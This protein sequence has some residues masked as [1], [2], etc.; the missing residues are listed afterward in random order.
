MLAPCVILTHPGTVG[1]PGFVAVCELYDTFRP[2]QKYN[3]IITGCHSSL[4]HLGQGGSPVPNVTSLCTA[5]A[6]GPCHP[7]SHLCTDR[8]GVGITSGQLASG[9]P[10]APKSNRHCPGEVGKPYE[11]TC[12]HGLVY[13]YLFCPCPVLGNSV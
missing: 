3:T 9:R 7:R 8:S 11:T 10:V 4:L 1:S 13:F 5:A 6:E 12:V 2:F